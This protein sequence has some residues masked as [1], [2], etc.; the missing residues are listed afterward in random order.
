VPTGSLSAAADWRPLLQ[1]ANRRRALQAVDA[2]AESVRS[3]SPG[4]RDPSLAG[5]QAGL[6]LLYAW[7]AE[8]GRSP[9]A[10]DLAWQCLDRAIDA[11]AAEEIGSWFWE[12]FTGVAWAGELLDRLLGGG[13]EGGDAASGNEAVDEVL[14]R[15]LSHPRGWPAPHDLVVG[16]TGLGVYA[17]E[18]Y[19]RPSAAEC[20]RHVVERLQESAQ[21]DRHG[22]YW[23]TP[24]AG[25]WEPEERREYP[26]GR[27]DLG[28]AHGVA[29]AIG[30]L[31]ALCGAGVEQARARPLLEGA[32]RWLMAQAVATES[33]PTFPIWVAPGFDPVPARCAWCY[34]DPGVAA[35]LWMAAQGAGEPQ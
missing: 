35:A 15:L 20:L 22:I 3:L 25:I 8:A 14:A 33:G 31:G 21:R 6:A 27:A 11:V 24:P 32:V 9:Q 18:R 28:V 5:G 19:P 30:L 17:L 2:I 13:V 4:E 16:A 26:S 29:G 7:L 34:G 10:S 12:G 1:G 23:W